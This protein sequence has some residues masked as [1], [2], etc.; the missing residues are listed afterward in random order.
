MKDDAATIPA[1]DG[2]FHPRSALEVQLQLEADALAHLAHKVDVEVGSGWQI[3]FETQNCE[4]SRFP[5]VG[6]TLQGRHL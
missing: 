4:C 3:M 2:F 6:R 1:C 5:D